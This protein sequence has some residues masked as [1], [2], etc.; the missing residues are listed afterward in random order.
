M[1]YSTVGSLTF[2]NN[3]DSS[4]K[5]ESTD[6]HWFYQG[7]TPTN[8]PSGGQAQYKGNSYVF[9]Y[10]P[11]E[12]DRTYHDTQADAQF[13]VDFG[14]KTIAGKLDNK[15]LLD[16]DDPNSLKE[17]FSFN[18]KVHGNS[19]SAKEEQDKIYYHGGFFGPNAEELSG[20]MRHDDDKLKGY[21]GAHKQ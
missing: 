5:S 13:D 15:V 9:S 17:G 11:D 8:M 6:S 14:A 12:G 16:S 10:G 1:R 19:F 4:G 2:L 20:V 7:I 3:V 18:G 21:F